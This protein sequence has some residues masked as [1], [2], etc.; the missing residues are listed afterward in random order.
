M[1]GE[2]RRQI[3][4]G[5]ADELVGEIYLENEKSYQHMK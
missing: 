5:G 2:C 3:R 4:I 1:L